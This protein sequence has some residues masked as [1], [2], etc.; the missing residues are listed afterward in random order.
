MKFYNRENELLELSKLWKQADSSGKLVVLT[1]RRRMGKTLLSTE[2]V[3]DLPFLY[4]FV[5]KK[6][7]TLLCQDF[8]PL[9]KNRMNLP[10]LGEIKHF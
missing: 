4:L 7:E 2:F 8:V 1:G 5:E 10:V 9:L 3:K 6:P